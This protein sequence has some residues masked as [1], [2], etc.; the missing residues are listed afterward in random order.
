MRKIP[1]I[2]SLVL[3]LSLYT[4]AEGKYRYDRPF[5][6]MSPEI[7]AQGGS[8]TAIAKGFN[9]LMTN[10]A[11]FA[12]SRDYKYKAR[13]GAQRVL[14]E[15][16][17]GEVT[18]L[19]ILPWAM[20]NPFTFFEDES[21]GSIIAALLKQSETNGIGGGVQIGGGYIGRGL[22]IGL[23]G[24]V[25]TDFQQSDTIL[26]VRGDVSFTM[27]LI[28]GY[29][30]KFELGPIDLSIGADMRPMWRMKARDIT[31]NSFLSLVL[32]DGDIDLSSIE[33]LTGFAIG[34]DLG[35]IAQ[36]NFLKLGLSLRDIGHTRYLYQLTDVSRLQNSPFKGSTY[37]GLEYITPMTMRL[38]L[39]IHPYFGHISKIIDPKIHLE[40]V[41]PL[42]DTSLVVS[43]GK[44]SN[45]AKLHAGL[46]VKFVQ[47]IAIRAGFSSGYLS[48]GVGFDLFIAEINAAIFSK[49]RGSHSG[50]KQQM[51]TSLE[52]VFR[53]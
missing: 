53:F 23:V 41:I 48:A 47:H 9:S 42:I 6:W 36:W 37:D 25:D 51:G 15:K 29:A 2:I 20:V 4:H 16:E 52:L 34:F 18:I 10:P 26:G 17:K 22:G 21:K 7:M 45:L 32:G 24:V 5:G 35:M 49:E 1:L 12:M 31:V 30:H 19:G 28:G 11:G 13:E 39:G 3:F 43:Y 8:F 33:A 44:Q 50:S 46:E 27:A 40:Y 38:G 14:G